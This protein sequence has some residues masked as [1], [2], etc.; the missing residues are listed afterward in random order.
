MCCMIKMLDVLRT[1]DTV[2]IELFYNLSI[3]VRCHLKIH[4]RNFTHE[5]KFTYLKEYN[6]TFEAGAYAGV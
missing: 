6:T 4:S 2:L 1:L 3:R 5:I